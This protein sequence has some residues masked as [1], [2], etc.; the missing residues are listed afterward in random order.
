MGYPYEESW[1]KIEG[2]NGKLEI[3]HDKAK[4]FIDALDQDRRDHIVG[5]G[6]GGKGYPDDLTSAGQQISAQDVGAGG[7][8]VKTSYPAGEV[9]WKS[10]QNVNTQFPKAHAEWLKAY[11]DVVEALYDAAGLYRKSEADSTP[12]AG[13]TDSP[14]GTPTTANQP[15]ATSGTDQT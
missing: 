15:S 10:I 14:S 7:D 5:K 12:T 11:K 3:D 9:I 6:A 8:G 4:K 13:T 2:Q 1:P